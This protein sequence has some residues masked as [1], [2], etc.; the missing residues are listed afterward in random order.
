[1]WGLSIYITI[2]DISGAREL[3]RLTLF[4]VI[5]NNKYRGHRVVPVERTSNKGYWYRVHS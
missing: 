4:G 2:I 5:S 1:M 3:R